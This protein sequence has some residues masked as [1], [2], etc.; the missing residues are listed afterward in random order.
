MIPVEGLGSGEH[1]EFWMLLMVLVCA[2]NTGQRRESLIASI[3]L[4]EGED[5]RERQGSRNN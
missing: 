5:P 4:V 2:E 3:I 1:H